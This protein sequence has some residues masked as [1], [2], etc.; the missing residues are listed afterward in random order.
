MP[1]RLHSASSGLPNGG[2]VRAH[3]HRRLAAVHRAT[4]RR[5]RASAT[6]Q[7]QYAWLLTS[8]LLLAG[9]A[10]VASP[11]PVLMAVVTD[12]TGWRGSVLSLCTAA[13]VERLVAA[14]DPQARRAYELEVSLDEGPSFDAMHG[15]SSVASGAELR[16]RW[17]RY[18]RE[19]A[20]LGVQ[21]VAAVPVDLGSSLVGSLTVTGSAVPEGW[22]SEHLAELAGALGEVLT[23]RE[24]SDGGLDLLGMDQFEDADHQ[25]ALHQAAGVLHA[26]CGLPI[27]DGVAL[28]RAHAYAE[29]RSVA[30]VAADVLGGVTFEP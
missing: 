26:R 15:R 9:E 29:D 22:V 19:A 27:D 23:S 6:L 12:R 18:G 7:G 8:W 1:R 20:E 17:P 16:R 24:R 14:S 5:Q 13:G 25:P 30:D 11:R 2:G 3:V 10:A 4:E 21:A 28:I